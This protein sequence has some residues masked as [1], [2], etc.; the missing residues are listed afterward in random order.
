MERPLSPRCHHPGPGVPKWGTVLP[1]H[2]RGH[3]QCLETS[4]VV[5]TLGGEGGESY[6][7]REG[8][9]QGC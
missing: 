8:G 9:G 1:P 7:Y 5:P 6:R 4:V 2:L 3:W